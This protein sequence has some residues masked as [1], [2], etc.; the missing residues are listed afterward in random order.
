MILIFIFII[1][2]KNNYRNV[3][4]KEDYTIIWITTKGIELNIQDILEKKEEEKEKIK[5]NSE[6]EELKIKLSKL[7]HLDKDYELVY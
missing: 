4:E 5:L 2:F 6:I 3:I 1:N 7:E